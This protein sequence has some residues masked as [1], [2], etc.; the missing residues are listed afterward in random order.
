MNAGV[1]NDPQLKGVTGSPSQATSV[2]AHTI[3][4]VILQE[5][6]ASYDLSLGLF[7]ILQGARPSVIE[8]LQLDMLLTADFLSDVTL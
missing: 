6:L 4:A 7:S 2:L 1:G 5:A 3:K 8:V